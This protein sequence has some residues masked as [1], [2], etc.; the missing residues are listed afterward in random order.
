MKDGDVQMFC[1]DPDSWKELWDEI[2]GKENVKV[3][4]YGTEVRRDEVNKE[5]DSVFFL[6]TWS[7]TRL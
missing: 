3:E 6:L 1:H 7:I 4:A 5:V 2:F